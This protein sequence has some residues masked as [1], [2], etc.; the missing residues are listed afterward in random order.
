[1]QLKQE[2]RINAPRERVFAALNDVNILKQAIPGC[3]EMEQISDTKF[4]ATVI[5]KVGPIKI[6]FLGEV[7]LSEVVP[8]ASYTLTGQGKGGTEGFAK[9]KADVNLVEDKGAT[10]LTYDVTVDVGGKLAQM[11]GRLIEGTSKKRANEF[12]QNFEKLVNDENAEEEKEEEI[13][14]DKQASY[15]SPL[16]V[17]SFALVTLVLAYVFLF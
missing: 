7:N 4:S 13:N 14:V 2:V 10:L 9:M 17:G 5:S 11:G 8:P 3:S 15:F 12:F 6:K 16:K 1:M